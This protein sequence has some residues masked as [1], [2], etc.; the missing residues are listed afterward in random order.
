LEKA[1]DRRP[2]V[3]VSDMMMDGPALVA[4]LAS[5]CRLSNVTVVLNSA[6]AAPSDL[7]VSAFSKKPYDPAQLLGL[8]HCSVEG[9][10]N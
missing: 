8:I 6:V 3:V 5:D 7:S 9:H 10:R 2:D 4:A 1:Q